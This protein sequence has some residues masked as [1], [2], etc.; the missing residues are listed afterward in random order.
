LF[1]KFLEEAVFWYLLW[2]FSLM[3]YRVLM[4]LDNVLNLQKSLFFWKSE[5]FWDFRKWIAT[6][7][8]S[9]SWKQSA[10][11]HA[12]VQLVKLCL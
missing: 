3:V 11:Y 10:F 6:E 8:S 12:S 7:L 9:R 5:N 2:I 1:N 4:Y